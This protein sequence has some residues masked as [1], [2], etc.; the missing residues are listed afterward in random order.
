MG[1]KMMCD[2]AFGLPK[3]LPTRNAYDWHGMV[4]KKLRMLGYATN[5]SVLM[6][7]GKA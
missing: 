1:N 5:K 7:I 2:N 6:R 4:K 3:A